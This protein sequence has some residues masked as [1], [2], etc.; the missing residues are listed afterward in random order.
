VRLPGHRPRPGFHRDPW[1]MAPEA[2]TYDLA[3]E[4]VDGST[5]APESGTPE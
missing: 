3:A 4:V 2:V 1:L 5:V